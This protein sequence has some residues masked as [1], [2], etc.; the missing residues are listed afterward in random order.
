MTTIK[1]DSAI[2]L[3][4]VVLQ[5]SS[6]AKELSTGLAPA[7]GGNAA[8]ASLA[9]DSILHEVTLESLKNVFMIASA[10]KVR[11]PLCPCGNPCCSSQ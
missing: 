2:P 8:S 7:R 11:F 1:N 6:L 5:V 3:A 4:A 9:R 10:D